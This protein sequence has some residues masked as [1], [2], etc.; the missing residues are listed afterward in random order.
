MSLD[1]S[2]TASRPVEIY[3]A[4]IT[5]NLKVMAEKAGLYY[6]LWRPEEIGVY[7]AHHLIPFLKAGLILLKTD[8]DRYKE[9][10]DAKGWGTYDQL[11]S[12]VEKYLRACE[13]NS[14]A[15]IGVSR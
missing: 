7:H 5:H 12:F 9:Y 14:E 15:V 6:P 11:I 13:M 10:N 1:V 2:L 8:P 4:N 3:E